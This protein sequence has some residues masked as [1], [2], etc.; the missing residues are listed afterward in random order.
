MSSWLVSFCPSWVW[1]CPTVTLGGATFH[2]VS[3]CPSQEWWP[4]G[5]V[6][7]SRTLIVSGMAHANPGELTDHILFVFSSFPPCY[8]QML[9]SRQNRTGKRFIHLPSPPD[10]MLLA[11]NA[12][13]VQIF[14]VTYTRLTSCRWRR[15]SFRMQVL[16]LIYPLYAQRRLPYPR[17][18]T[19]DRGPKW[20]RRRRRHTLSLRSTRPAPVLR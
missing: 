6:I 3:A 13:R 9:I 7:L 16:S 8:Q 10:I 5:R 2:Q 1:R 4:V 15:T 17:R 18:R 20:E 12:T 19:S 11:G 14:Y